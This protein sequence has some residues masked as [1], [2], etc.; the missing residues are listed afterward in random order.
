ML[1]FSLFVFLA[2]C[3][4]GLQAQDPMFSQFYAAPLRLNP[5]LAGVSTAPRVALNYRTQH[6]SF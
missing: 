2:A 6:T 3:G 1:R 5:A 4:L